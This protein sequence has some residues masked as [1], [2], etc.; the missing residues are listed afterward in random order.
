MCTYVHAYG[1]VDMCVCVYVYGCLSVRV[2][3]Y[4]HVYVY[5]HGCVCVNL[6]MYMGVCVCGHVYMY[7]CAC[8]CIIFV[9][10]CVSI[11]YVPFKF[12][13]FKC[14][15]ILERWCKILWF[16]YKQ[17]DFKLYD[18]ITYSLLSISARRATLDQSPRGN[19]DKRKTPPKKYR[20][21]KKEER[22]WHGFTYISSLES[23]LSL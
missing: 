17:F 5:M 10:E 22:L 12:I 11:N 13:S 7:M 18:V 16:T 8:V 1:Y 21:H 6:Y 15:H 4:V 2:Y 9:C 3:I 23:R 20:V 19:G 14:C